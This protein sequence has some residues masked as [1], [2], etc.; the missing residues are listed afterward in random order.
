MCTLLSVGAQVHWHAPV[1]GQTKPLLITA[2]K[3]LVTADTDTILAGGENA[4]G[5]VRRNTDMMNVEGGYCPSTLAPLAR[6]TGACT[7]NRP[8]ITMHD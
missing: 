5:S 2:P 7:I 3:L 8:L 1:S 4:Q 6:S